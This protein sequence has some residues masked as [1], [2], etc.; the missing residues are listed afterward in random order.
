MPS[1]ATKSGLDRRVVQ[2]GFVVDEVELGEGFVRVLR[3]TRLSLPTEMSARNIS[4][5][6]KAAGA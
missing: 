6:V 3:S 4:C 1:C 5:R 2:V